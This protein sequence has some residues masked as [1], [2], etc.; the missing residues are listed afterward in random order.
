MGFLT[1]GEYF[2][3]TPVDYIDY[4]TPIG[5]LAVFIAASY[6]IATVVMFV[7]LAR[8]WLGISRS[9]VYYFVWTSNI[10]QFIYYIVM[11]LRYTPD[12]FPLLCWG[13]SVLGTITL[14]VVIMGQLE[15]L[16]VFT[17]NSRVLNRKIV[18]YLQIAFTIFTIGCLGGLYLS[19]FYIGYPRPA[20]LDKWHFYGYLAF[21][22]ACLFYETFHA[23]YVSRSVVDQ[24]QKRKQLVVSSSSKQNEEKVFHELYQLVIICIL[25]DWTA[26]IV[27]TSAWFLPKSNE[28]T[29]MGV[30]GNAIG[31][32]HILFMT[33]IFKKLKLVNVKRI[34]DSKF[35]SSIA[36]T[37]VSIFKTETEKSVH[38]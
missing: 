33:A 27:W 23:I 21:A 5:I 12:S 38:F 13:F 19:V 9:K 14:F 31:V 25:V 24:V 26:A 34:K 15:I 17:I 4:K 6:L 3:G 37:S 1:S 30:I 20:I 16:K 35:E 29:A 10:I 8:G 28:A 32:G 2:D 7:L 36:Q 22:L 18:Y 11:I